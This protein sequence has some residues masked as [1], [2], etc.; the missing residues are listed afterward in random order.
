MEMEY[1][2]EM[3]KRKNLMGI[4][5]AD[6]YAES[7]FAK[8]GYKIKEGSVLGQDGKK[9]YLYF[10]ADEEFLK[11]AEEKLKGLVK[12]TE[13]KVAGEIIE[14]LNEEE[15]QATSGFGDIFG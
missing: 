15:N 13:K 11:K 4:L 2:C 8:K 12:K 10:K 14:K 5:E 3:E 7:S 6:P 9:L 1:E